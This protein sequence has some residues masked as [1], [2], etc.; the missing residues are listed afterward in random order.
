MYKQIIYCSRLKEIYDEQ[1][2][3]HIVSHARKNNAN[4]GI[5]GYLVFGNQCFLQVIEGYVGPVEDLTKKIKNDQ[6]HEAFKLI[7]EEIIQYLDY[8]KW[9][10]GYSSLINQREIENNLD[11]DKLGKE[12]SLKILT[13]L[14]KKG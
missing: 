13:T 8:E 5:S 1:E 14:S 7:S 9:S 2:V 11:P 4:I 10:M 3:Y 6:R 12:E